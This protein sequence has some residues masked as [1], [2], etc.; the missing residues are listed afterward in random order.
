MHQFNFSGTELAMSLAPLVN[1]SKNAANTDSLASCPT[2]GDAFGSTYS[3]KTISGK[4]LIVLSNVRIGFY[5]DCGVCE[6]Q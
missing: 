3:H 6:Q 1:A 4:N 2:R 5:R